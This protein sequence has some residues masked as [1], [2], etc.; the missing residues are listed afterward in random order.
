MHAVKTVTSNNINAARAHFH[1]KHYDDTRKICRKLL[2]KNANDYDA[3]FLLGAVDWELKDYPNAEKHFTRAHELDPKNTDTLQNLGD[4]K[5]YNGKL[6]EADALY[7]T[8]IQLN[9][10]AAKAWVS[11][12]INGVNR[13]DAR[14][15]E[16]CFAKAL[17]LDPEYNYALLHLGRLYFRNGK[18]EAAIQCYYKVLEK[19]PTHLCA[20]E[21]LVNH[22]VEKGHLEVAAKHIDILKRFHANEPSTHI[23][24]ARLLNAQGNYKDA[25]PLLKKY[26]HLLY[27]NMPY[28]IAYALAMS[29]AESREK[30]IEVLNNSQPYVDH[31]EDEFCSVHF[32]LA[33]LY[34]AAN[35]FEH[36]WE[37]FVAA[38]NKRD[39][40]VGNLFSSKDLDDIINYYRKNPEAIS[41]HSERQS[42][43]PIFIVGMPRSGT[44]LTER[45]IQMHSKVF[46]GGEM[47]LMTEIQNYLTQTFK[48]KRYPK[49][50][51]QLNAEMFNKLTDE[52]QNKLDSFSGNSSYVT[53]KMPSN[54]YR[55]PL[56]KALFPNAKIIHCMRH[57]L[58]NCLSIYMQAF[59]PFRHP[60]AFALPRIADI[61]RKYWEMMKVWEEIGIE[62]MH[63]PY[64]KLVA[65]QEDMSKELI[66]FCGLDWD[67]N[68]LK[69]YESKKVVSTASRH[70]V[71]Q[72]MYSSSVARWRNYEHHLD[73]VKDLLGDIIEEYETRIPESR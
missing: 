56:L 71:N 1:K 23:S 31:Q 9:P 67:E 43:T 36:A 35:E 24:E 39:A 37:H 44:S 14:V 53:D 17:N 25:L 60:Y 22:L 68:C 11:L 54:A 42:D 65:N 13:G 45:I 57:P 69:F 61:Y 55:V 47:T 40:V 33:H 12:G 59:W 3:H 58:D 19:D 46:A 7:K 62:V 41:R 10:K 27:N 52:Y 32:Q 16:T 21:A 64:E 72:K 34:D 49:A 48:V 4:C 20:H 6:D 29:K 38:N 66:A 30:A 50:L 8:V 73:P 28:T 63:S 2:K 51:E 5:R 18:D 70:Q 15:A 26:T